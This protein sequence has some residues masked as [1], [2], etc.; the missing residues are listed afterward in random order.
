M[1]ND[2]ATDELNTWI[3]LAAATAR[4][5]PK[6]T[7]CNGPDENQRREEDER[8]KEDD[9]AVHREIAWIELRL[10]LMNWTYFV[11]HGYTQRQ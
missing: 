8:E 7:L 11:L 10:A 1:E 4:V 2:Y 9:E 5:L 6:Q 3:T